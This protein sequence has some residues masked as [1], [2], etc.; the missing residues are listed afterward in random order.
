MKKPA[1]LVILSLFCFYLWSGDLNVFVEATRFLD[2]NLNTTLEINYQIPY[3]NLHFTRTENGYTANLEVEFMLMRSGKKVYDQTFT[4]GIILL[5]ESKTKS[6]DLFSDKITMTLAKHQFDV[7]VIF[8][9]T[10]SSDT[11][12]WNYPFEVLSPENLL[13]DLE[14]SSSVVPDTTGFLAKFHRGDYLYNVTAN[15][16]FSTDKTGEV[17]LY[18]ELYNP[19][20]TSKE[21]QIVTS[22]SKKDSLIRQ[23]DEKVTVDRLINDMN[24]HIPLAE[25]EDGFYNIE[26]TVTDTPTNRSESRS[27]YFSVRTPKFFS[28]RMFVNVEDEYK[29]ISYFVSS[30]QLK[31]WSTLSDEGKKAFI[32]NFWT[33]SDNDTSTDKNEFFD[34]VKD[35]IYYTNQEYTHFKDGWNSDRGRI[36]IRNGKPDE[37][38]KDNTGLYTSASKY[39]PKDYEIWR[40]RTGTNRTYIFLDIQGTGNFRLIYADNDDMEGTDPNWEDNFGDDFDQSVLN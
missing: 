40:Y 6:S 14:F 31:I 26:V 23:L 32:G 12:F 8:L 22:V 33:A 20:E 24:A 17:V 29:L 4:N 37:I 5:T 11:N 35:R 19:S 27:S 3:K 9:D 7:N 36:Y 38:I 16:I 30:E 39:T 25:L 15:H 21:Y 18:Y 1:F 2:Q 10:N 13:S 28:E 34:L